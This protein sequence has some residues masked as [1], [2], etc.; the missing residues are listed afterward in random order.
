M[1]SDVQLSPDPSVR[2]IEGFRNNSPYIPWSDMVSEESAW[3]GCAIDTSS[4]GLPVGLQVGHKARRPHDRVG[5]TQGPNVVFNLPLTL[6]L[7]HAGTKPSVEDRGIY[8]V[9]DAS[10]SRRIDK[11]LALSYLP[12]NTNPAILLDGKGTVR[13]LQC[14][15]Q[16]AGVVEVPSHHVHA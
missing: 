6:E 14:G 4:R 5:Y 15:I 11:C 1:P 10:A 7:R 13:A 8:E 3:K 2:I 16:R 12:V 9:L